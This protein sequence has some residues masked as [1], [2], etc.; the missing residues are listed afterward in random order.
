MAL[1]I[2]REL[3]NLTLKLQNELLDPQPLAT[4]KILRTNNLFL[5]N[6]LSSLDPAPL[7]PA[8]RVVPE[9]ESESSEGSETDWEAAEEAALQK[10]DEAISSRS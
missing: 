4:Q 1:E 8:P 3:I 7:A 5:I 9:S 2:Q 10:L 6:I